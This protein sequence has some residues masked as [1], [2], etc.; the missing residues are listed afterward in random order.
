MEADRKDSG[1]AGFA[2]VSH[3]EE[4]IAYRVGNK[5]TLRS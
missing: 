5:V 2:P 4:R 1:N 3:P